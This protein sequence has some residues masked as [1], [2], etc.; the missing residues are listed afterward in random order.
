MPEFERTKGFKKEA[1]QY[2]V[3][4]LCGNN[5]FL[6]NTDRNDMQSGTLTCTSEC[7]SYPI[8]EG[9]PRLLPELNG[10]KQNG[11]EYQNS[12]VDKF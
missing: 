3:C 11:E 7:R 8:R 2:L 6:E 5:L 4:P 10:Q 12:V 9:V 1:L